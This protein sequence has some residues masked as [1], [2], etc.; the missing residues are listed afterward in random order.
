MR[1][2]GYR[3]RNSDSVTV[4]DDEYIGLMFSRALSLSRG[5]GGGIVEN[6]SSRRGVE[7]GIRT[8]GDSRRRAPTV[9]PSPFIVGPMR[10]V[11]ACP[12]DTL[13]PTCARVLH[14]SM[15]ARCQSDHRQIGRVPAA[16]STPIIHRSSLSCAT[17]RLDSIHHRC[18]R[19]QLRPATAASVSVN[20]SRRVRHSPH[21]ADTP[22]PRH[23]ALWTDGRSFR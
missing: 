15:S 7:A 12:A 22:A 9:P 16:A 23:R 21:R 6:G 8:I 4:Q 5:G 17:T 3:G 10:S 19:R 1:G 14:Q 2:A 18:R 20:G 13:P 11:P